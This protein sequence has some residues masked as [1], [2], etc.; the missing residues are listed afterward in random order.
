MDVTAL[1]ALAASMPVIEQ[2]KGIVMG[3]YGVDADASFAVLSRV[4]SSGNLK[5]R[6]LAASV[7][8]AASRRTGSTQGP[9]PSP[10]ERVG[11]VIHDALTTDERSAT[12]RA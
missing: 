1:R 6:V 7:V 3:C 9:G 12:E 2:A 11:R 4:A 8:E 5:L 10:C